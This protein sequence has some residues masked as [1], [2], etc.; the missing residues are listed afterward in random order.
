MVEPGRVWA[1]RAPPS[2]CGELDCALAR[3]GR[4]HVTTASRD[5]GAALSFR[6][7]VVG[8]E[9]LEGSGELGSG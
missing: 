8:S 9:Y 5:T 7:W 3:T 1:Q 6:R 2:G 4:G